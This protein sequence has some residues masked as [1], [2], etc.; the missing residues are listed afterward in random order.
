[1]AVGDQVTQAEVNATALQIVRQVYAAFANVQRFQAYLAAT[2]DATITGL[3]TGGA[4]QLTTGDVA[5]LKSAFTDLNLLRTV[6]EGTATQA[7]LKDFR[8]FAGQILGPGLY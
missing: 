1:M 5:T 8:T 4:T 2:P 7:S 3:P 6:F